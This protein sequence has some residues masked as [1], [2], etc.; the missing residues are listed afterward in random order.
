MSIQEIQFIYPECQ[1]RGATNSATPA[2]A[3]Q[4]VNVQR[5]ISLRNTHSECNFKQW[6]CFA[7]PEFQCKSRF[8]NLLWYLLDQKKWEKAAITMWKEEQTQGQ[9]RFRT[10]LRRAWMD[11][12]ACRSSKQTQWDAIPLRCGCPTLF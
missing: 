12:I 8:F 2:I 7:A 5:I 4:E 1:C 9:V 10:M 3:H 11:T 6:V